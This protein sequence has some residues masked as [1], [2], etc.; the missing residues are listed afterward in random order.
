MKELQLVER[1][2]YGDDGNEL[3]GTTKMIKSPSCSLIGLSEPN[4]AISSMSSTFMDGDIQMV[5]RH[6]SASDLGPRPIMTPSLPPLVLQDAHCS[7]LSARS[8][9]S[10]YSDCSTMSIYEEAFEAL[11]QFD[12][13]KRSSLN[14]IKVRCRE[15]NGSLDD[16]NTS[17]NGPAETG[18]KQVFSMK[19]DGPSALEGHSFVCMKKNLANLKVNSNPPG[20]YNPY[21]LAGALAD[22]KSRGS[23]GD[24]GCV[25]GHARNIGTSRLHRSSSVCSEP[26]VLILIPGAKKKG[27]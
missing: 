24:N 16:A 23:P 13:L 17:T 10:T 21:D 15:D 20:T 27:G 8:D 6:S 1:T 12:I 2:V 4:S 14:P 25:S 26:E 5:S 3:L 18:L 22:F 19:Q 7:C 9:L 11:T